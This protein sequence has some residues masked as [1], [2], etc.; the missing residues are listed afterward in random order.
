MDPAR[1]GKVHCK[2]RI[3]ICHTLLLLGEKLL[4]LGGSG[5]PATPLPKSGLLDKDPW[6]IADVPRIINHGEERCYMYKDIY[7]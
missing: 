7:R 3:T 6:L 5:P 2:P 4:C 1:R